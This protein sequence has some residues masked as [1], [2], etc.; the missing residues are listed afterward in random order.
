MRGV[1]GGEG[2]IAGPGYETKSVSTPVRGTV[3]YVHV[4]RILYSGHVNCM[5]DTTYD[6][7]KS[8]ILFLTV[9]QS[10]EVYM[11]LYRY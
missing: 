1:V 8:I 9:K 3:V 11:Y 2:G 4:L 6:G 5:M 7:Y 10:I